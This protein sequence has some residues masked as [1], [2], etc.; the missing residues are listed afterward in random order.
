MVYRVLRSMAV[1]MIL[2]LFAF[3]G[4][5]N[6]STS[7]YGN[8]SSTTTTKTAPNTVAIANFTFSPSSLTIA[9]GTIITW[10]NNDGVA[11]TS[12]SDN[13]VWDTGSIVPGASK[14]VTFGTS[15][16]F[17]YHCTVHPMMTGTIIVQ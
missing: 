14:A 8:S 17:T 2:L 3:L 11:H 7:P 10:V 12:T 4:C 16:T 5:N 13:N 1:L 15:G 9:K 6:G